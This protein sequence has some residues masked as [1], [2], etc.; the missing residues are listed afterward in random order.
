[1][2]GG[3]VGLELSATRRRALAGQSGWVGATSLI[4]HPAPTL[5]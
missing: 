1:M 4:L 5:S 3:T 2:V